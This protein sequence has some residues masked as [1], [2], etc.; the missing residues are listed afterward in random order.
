MIRTRRG[1]VVG[2]KDDGEKKK[3][4]GVVEKKDEKT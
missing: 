2:L 3:N 4:E 1:T